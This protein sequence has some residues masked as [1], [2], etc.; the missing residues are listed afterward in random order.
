M[1]IP[2]KFQEAL[3]LGVKFGIGPGEVVSRYGRLRTRFPLKGAPTDGPYRITGWPPTTTAPSLGFEIKATKFNWWFPWISSSINRYP[4]DFL[5]PSPPWF[6]ANQSFG[7]LLPTQN[8]SVTRQSDVSKQNTFSTRVKILQAKLSAGSARGLLILT[9]TWT[10]SLWSKFYQRTSND[11]VIPT[12]PK[13]FSTT[14]NPSHEKTFA[15]DESLPWRL[16][17][18]SGVFHLTF[19]GKSLPTNLA[20]NR[21]KRTHVCCKGACVFRF[22]TLWFWGYCD[23]VVGCPATE[24]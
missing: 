17:G 9:V 23:T 4:L 18:F 11:L 24:A 10:G 13:K 2:H 16:L 19:L 5:P 6:F 21:D 12:R 15:H 22:E 20:L 14:M 3:I 1:E 8:S 7:G